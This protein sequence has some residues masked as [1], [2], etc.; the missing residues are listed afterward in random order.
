MSLDSLA[1]GL[2]SSG[3]GLFVV[4]SDLS[5]RELHCLSLSVI[6]L[7]NTNILEA[8]MDSSSYQQCREMLLGVC[9]GSWGLVHHPNISSVLSLFP[10]KLSRVLSYESAIY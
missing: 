10:L 9:P 6:L 4:V 2:G 3:A 5:R 1:L 7:A 8:K